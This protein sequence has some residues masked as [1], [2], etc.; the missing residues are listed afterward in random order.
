[1]TVTSLSP[2]AA[3]ARSRALS[4]PSVTNVYTPQSRISV[5][6]L[7]VTTKTGGGADPSDRRLPFMAGSHRTGRPQIAG[8]QLSERVCLGC[9]IE[10]TR[11]NRQ[12][13]GVARARGQREAGLG[14]AA[15][16]P[17]AAHPQDTM[18]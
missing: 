14:Q 16:I 5:G 7:W 1:M 15:C 8:S 10:R 3:L 9:A 18:R 13:K 11:S 12:R 6:A 2:P 4:V 17:A